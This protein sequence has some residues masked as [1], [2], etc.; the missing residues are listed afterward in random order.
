M[1]ENQKLR[2]TPEI[3][4]SLVYSYKHFKG[5]L[6]NGQMPEN[7]LGFTE[8]ELK[9]ILLVVGR[10]IGITYAENEER[11]IN[12][13]IAELE[14]I[15]DGDPQAQANIPPQLETLVKDLETQ[16]KLAAEAKKDPRY[17]LSLDA[18]ILITKRDLERT[19]ERIVQVTPPIP[20]PHVPDRDTIKPFIPQKEEAEVQKPSYRDEIK[21]WID[22]ERL[23][24]IVAALEK[25]NAPKETV[26]PIAK[27]IKS[28]TDQEQRLPTVFEVEQIV[29]SA[30]QNQ[31]L[32]IEADNI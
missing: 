18:Q 30:F 1:E 2:I 13:I 14:K 24:K 32:P 31:N 15:K 28:L 7:D 4:Q 25:A 12:A 27:N 21:E 23:A 3:A 5:E 17:K 22:Q 16:K 10:A 26:A 20:A 9:G 6:V 8:Q 29:L 19:Q 11:L